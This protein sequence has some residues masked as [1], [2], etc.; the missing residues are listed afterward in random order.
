[1]EV[2]KA[3]REINVIFTT[4]L[5]FSSNQFAF[6]DFSVLEPRVLIIEKHF[7]LIRQLTDRT[8]ALKARYQTCISPFLY[9]F[10]VNVNG[11]GKNQYTSTS[12]DPEPDGR[13]KKEDES[14][15]YEW[16]SIRWMNLVII[17]HRRWKNYFRVTSYWN[18]RELSESR[19]CLCTIPPNRPLQNPTP[20]VGAQDK[21]LWRTSSLP[22]VSVAFVPS[23]TKDIIKFH[24]FTHV[25]PKLLVPLRFAMWR[26]VSSAGGDKMAWHDVH[27]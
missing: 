21:I 25:R 11:N 22:F 1:M 3:R 16:H 12:P 26:S 20:S 24:L 6:H 14:R 10:C 4:I 18:E 5:H 17:S 19:R 8:W 13:T 7:P 2:I 23:L 9:A 27:K 15:Q